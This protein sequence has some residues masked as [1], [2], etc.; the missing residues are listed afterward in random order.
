MG[1]THGH[2][3]DSELRGRTVNCHPLIQSS[4][5]HL[6]QTVVPLSRTYI[7]TEGLQSPSVYPSR[8]QGEKPSTS[9]SPNTERRWCR[10][11]FFFFSYLS[12]NGLKLLKER[13]VYDISE[14]YHS[15]W[16]H[17]QW[18]FK[19]SPADSRKRDLCLWPEAKSQWPNGDGSSLSFLTVNPYIWAEMFKCLLWDDLL[20]H[21]GFPKLECVVRDGTGA[22]ICLFWFPEQPIFTFL[23]SQTEESTGPAHPAALAGLVFQMRKDLPLDSYIVICW[24]LP[25]DPPFP[26]MKKYGVT[27]SKQ[28]EFLDQ[29]LFVCG[30]GDVNTVLPTFSRSL[31]GSLPHNWRR[32]DN[33]IRL[34]SD[35]NLPFLCN[36][37]S[38]EL[39]TRW[40]HEEPKT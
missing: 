5:R 25:L 21:G 27:R 37:M 17:Y 26:K 30:G 18:T 29:S 20:H 1:V 14:K 32:Y 34:R 28:V 39:N 10:V 35:T 19:M 3:A 6:N 23:S 33:Q 16:F 40:V 31:G 8:I 7:R 15:W 22:G 36:N 11:V 13:M 4:N 38:K 24:H 9:P 12:A 2:L